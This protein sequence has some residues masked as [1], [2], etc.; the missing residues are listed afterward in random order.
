MSQKIEKLTEAKTKLEAASAIVNEYQ[1]GLERLALTR[2]KE[3][4]ELLS[5]LHNDL[6][7]LEDSNLW[8]L[9]E[10]RS[11]KPARILCE[12]YAKLIGRAHI[13]PAAP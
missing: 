2:V 4:E 7:E 8:L 9:D 3:A 13:Q 12:I 10:S 5:S 11:L 1:I 6:V